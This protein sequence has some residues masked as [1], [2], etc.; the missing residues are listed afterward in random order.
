MTKQDLVDR[1]SD[2]VGLSKPEVQAVLDGMLA[3]VME[4]VSKGE[5]VEL[6]RFGV[7]K[8]V[9]R[10]GRHLR[11]P[12]GVHEIDLPDRPTAVFVPAAE[13]RARMTALTERRTVV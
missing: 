4:A 12:D 6:R 7:W 5:R 8:P 9:N 1:L 2:G 13:F 10:K 3:L 11:T